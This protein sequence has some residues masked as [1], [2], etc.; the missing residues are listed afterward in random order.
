MTRQENLP[1]PQHPSRRDFLKT[2]LAATAGAAVVGALPLARTAHAAG[3]DTI[4]IA[5]VGCGGRGTGAAVNALST[6]ANVK[7]VAMADA[8]A[9]SLEGSLA[10]I[11]KECKD[12]VDVPP[13]RRF[14]GLDAY[15]KAIQ[16]G[17]DLVLFCTPPGFRPAHFEAAVKAG[18]HVFL[19]KPVATDAP[20]V[21]PHPGRQ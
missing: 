16:S 9:D 8:F 20:G 6:K 10:A 21:P 15:Q 11:S 2:S 5:L 12:R 17:V 1:S 14:T 3:D 7:L 19:E 13:E 4:K 18:K